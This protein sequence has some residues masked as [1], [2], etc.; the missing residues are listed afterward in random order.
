MISLLTF[1]SFN[2]NSGFS[3][4]FCMLIWKKKVSFVDKT[5]IV[6]TTVSLL[7]ISLPGTLCLKRKFLFDKN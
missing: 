5:R 3:E 1:M 4:F 6:K 2:A 7:K